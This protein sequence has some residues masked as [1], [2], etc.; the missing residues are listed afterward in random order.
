MHPS[1]ED[2]GELSG[3]AAL[4][5]AAPGAYNKNIQLRPSM[6]MTLELP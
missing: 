5:A 3:T 4:D 6:S 2:L 1:H